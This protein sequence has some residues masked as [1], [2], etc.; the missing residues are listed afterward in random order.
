MARIYLITCVD[1]AAG[2]AEHREYQ[3]SS[4]GEALLMAER[5]NAGA[6]SL[7]YG[8]QPE[9]YPEARDEGIEFNEPD[10]LLL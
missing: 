8:I 1:D 3:A 5:D 7:T 2:T 9:D 6:R 10:G 4:V